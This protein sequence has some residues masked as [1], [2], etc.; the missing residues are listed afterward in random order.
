[1]RLITQPRASM[2]EPEIVICSDAAELSQRGA[3]QF[4]QLAHRSVEI[5]GRF[6][7]ALSGGSTPKALYSLLASPGYKERV[8]WKNVHLFWADERCVPP[9]HSES[10]FRM[11][12]ESLLGKIDIPPENVHRMAGE[13]EPE[14]AAAEYEETLRRFFQIPVGERPRFDLI[15]LGIGEDGHTASLFPGSAALGETK[16]L[17]VAPYVEKLT[18]YRLTLTFPV[19]NHGAC[20]VFLIAGESKAAIVRQVLEAKGGAAVIPAARIRPADGRLVWLITQDA[21]PRRLVRQ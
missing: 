3:E 8:P 10:N 15:F 5:S 6:A 19:L 4:I 17:V 12:Q 11:V 13:K 20:V 14:T 2:A 1:V 16:R 18:A 9:D 21:A 7:V